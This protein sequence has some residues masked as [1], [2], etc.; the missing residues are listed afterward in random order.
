MISG[1]CKNMKNITVKDVGLSNQALRI[2][3]SA[4][5]FDCQGIERKFYSTMEKGFSSGGGGI[6]SRGGS[7]VIEQ[8]NKKI[9]GGKVGIVEGTRHAGERQ[10]QRK[11]LFLIGDGGRLRAVFEDDLQAAEPVREV[12]AQ[13]GGMERGV[14]HLAIT[15]TA[16]LGIIL[17]KELENDPIAK[18]RGIMGGGE[19]S[20]VG[21]ARVAHLQEGPGR[22]R[23]H[24]GGVEER[25]EERGAAG[26]VEGVLIDE[27]VVDKL[28]DDLEL[29]A[30]IPADRRKMQ[31][32]AA[33]VI[34]F[35]GVWFLVGE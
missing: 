35:I 13:D 9:K 7:R 2:S 12:R 18:E 28:A 21:S 6:Q 14:S 22:V 23:G 26:T 20:G 3:S 15:E 24:H 19:P 32:G 16:H 31:R 4:D 5:D 30:P 17:E 34:G 27:M 8:E 25:E 11:A 10:V 1:V 29:V 33:Q